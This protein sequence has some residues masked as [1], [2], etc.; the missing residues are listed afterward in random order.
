MAEA[1]KIGEA[2]ALLNLKPYVLRF[3]E[4]EFPDI[5]PLRTESGRRL[6][7]EE[8]VALLERIRF[9]LHERGLTIGGARKILGEEKERGVRYVF[10]LRGAIAETEFFSPVAVTPSPLSAAA[11]AAIPASSPPPTA[12]SAFP[13]SD[14]GEGIISA[15]SA[16]NKPLQTEHA[17]AEPVE[18]K[19]EEEEAE[20]EY[21]D[22]EEAEDL[23][24]YP[25]YAGLSTRL[26][27]GGQFSLPGLEKILPLLPGLLNNFAENVAYGGTDP[28][29]APAEPKGILPL[30]TASPARDT[31]GRTGGAFFSAKSG[32]SGK[33]FPASIVTELEEIAALLR[34]HPSPLKKAGQP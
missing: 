16:R 29:T 3:W 19:P 7:R 6:Y 34:R 5:V 24:L 22:E 28:D 20:E 25:P 11:P 12:P 14:P 30:F 4:T 13:R 33:S 10:N 9:L 2:A 18:E 23:D 15:A 27:R 31:S 32:P 21:P 1:Y 17:W 26:E 8:D